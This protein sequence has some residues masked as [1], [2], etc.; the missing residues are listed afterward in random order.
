M[1]LGSVVP[2]D[3]AGWRLVSFVYWV[4]AVSLK[5][6]DPPVKMS[7]VVAAAG[8]AVG[9]SA[10]AAPSALADVYNIDASHG[11]EV[12]I[13]DVGPWNSGYNGQVANNHV[14]KDKK[15]KKHDKIADMVK[16]RIDGGR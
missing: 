13:Q 6:R 8:I 12:A 11:G 14:K 15:H 1:P 4:P 7:R 10:V 9:L 16:E 2:P 5:R 3:W